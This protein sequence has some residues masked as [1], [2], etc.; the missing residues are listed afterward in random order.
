MSAATFQSMMARLVIEPA[1]RDEVLR[2]GLD[3]AAD[4][5]PLETRRLLAIAHSSGWCSTREPT[6]HAAC[7]TIATTAGFTP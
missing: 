7:R 6:R 2:D 1:W 4:L 3:A 5:T